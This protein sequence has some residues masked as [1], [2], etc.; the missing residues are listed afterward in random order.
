MNHLDKLNQFLDRSEQLN[1]EIPAK[2]KDFK[3]R[4]VI[5][6]PIKKEKESE[7][8]LPEIIEKE[9]NLEPLKTSPETE[10]AEKENLEKKEEESK[11]IPINQWSEDDK[12]REKLRDKGRN[13]LSNAELIAILIGSGSRS[14]SAVDL[15]KQILNHA[16]NNLNELGKVSIEEL[17]KNFHGIGEAKAITIIA[18]LELGRRR[19]MSKIKDRPHI[20]SSRD[21]F[22]VIA[23]MIMD[24]QHEEFWVLM[25]NRGNQVLKR[26]Q[27]SLGGVSG[28]IVD[29]KIIFKKALEIPASAII[30]CHNHPSGNLRPSGA[31]IEITKKVKEGGALIDINVLDHLIV[32][33][34]GYFSFADEGML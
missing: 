25:L 14:M 17:V 16:D 19:Q 15:A 34:R 2:K 23:P 1:L 11:Y 9:D 6:L 26:V 29:A 3:N 20:K 33:E 5:T 24:L 28:T 21:A 31:D 32:S 7:E 8:A 22:D 4:Q 10:V 30:L 18:A 12:P 13:A 27:V